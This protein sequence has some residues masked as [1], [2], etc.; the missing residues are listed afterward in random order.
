MKCVQFG[1]ECRDNKFS[2]EW[3]YSCSGHA[4]VIYDQKRREFRVKIN[5]ERNTY[6]IAIHVA[7]VKWASAEVDN[8]LSRTVFFSLT[9]PP[10]YETEPSKLGSQFPESSPLNA[11]LVEA[12][13]RSFSMFGLSRQAEPKRHRWAGIDTSHAV[14]SPYTSLAIRL[15]CNGDA[16]LDTFRRVARTARVKLERFAYPVVRRGLFSEA[17]RTQ[18]DAW[19]SVLPWKV[20]FRI[21]SL[22]RHLL[23]DLREIMA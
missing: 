15:E 9:H 8:H 4:E 1:W 20:A 5:G 23:L 12:M 14:V 21:E 22:A 13:A 17:V 2:V 7:Q 11:S 10:T 18:Y 6:F 3:E 19:V 16:D